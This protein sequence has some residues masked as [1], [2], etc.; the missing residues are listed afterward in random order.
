MAEPGPGSQTA[1]EEENAQAVEATTNTLG[2]V[3]QC[4]WAV[5][6]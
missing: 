2:G 3:R 6:G 1:E 4:P 5:Q